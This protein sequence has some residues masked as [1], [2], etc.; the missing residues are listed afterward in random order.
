[1][2]NSHRVLE[3]RKGSYGAL[4]RGFTL[5]ELLVVISIIALLLAIL[6]PA[7][8]RAREQARAVTCASNLRQIGLAG[9]MYCEANEDELMVYQRYYSQDEQF[10][11]AHDLCRYIGNNEGAKGME[12]DDW[13]AGDLVDLK[14]VLSVFMCPSARE[15]RDI[16][17]LNWRIRYGLNL[18]LS[19]HDMSF[20]NQESIIRKR[21][22]FTRPAQ[23]MWI[24]DSSDDTNEYVDERVL[25]YMLPK[26]RH[27]LIPDWQTAG[28]YYIPIADRHSRDANILFLD[29]HVAK[30]NYEDVQF[31]E[32]DEE[33]ERAQKRFLWAWNYD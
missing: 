20:Y 31:M 26:W 16:M 21:L 24:A 6:L 8:G 33:E 2:K 28:S 19:S 17:G 12:G 30:M 7:L 1:M 18:Q 25:K 13:V 11:W 32:E 27:Y 9:V 10:I 5:I 3:C 4:S 22:Q 29:G 23:R 14:K 15:R